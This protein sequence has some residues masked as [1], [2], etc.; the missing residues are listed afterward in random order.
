MFELRLSIVAGSLRY[1]N[2]MIYLPN[3]VYILMSAPA[4][5]ATRTF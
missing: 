1:D 3:E 5:A 4:A 2:I